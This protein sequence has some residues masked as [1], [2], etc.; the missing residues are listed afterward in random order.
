ME[1]NTW[2]FKLQSLSGNEYLK[3]LVFAVDVSGTNLLHSTTLSISDAEI[4][5]TLGMFDTY[6][7]EIITNN[8]S[9]LDVS[10]Y[11]LRWEIWSTSQGNETR[12][13][14]SSDIADSK[15]PNVTQFTQQSGN[16]LVNVLNLVLDWETN[17]Q[18][19]SSIS[20]FTW[21]LYIINPHRENVSNDESLNNSLSTITSP[22]YYL[23]NNALLKKCIGYIGGFRIIFTY[24]DNLQSYSVQMVIINS[25]DLVEQAINI[26][27][28]FNYHTIQDLQNNKPNTQVFEVTGLNDD[29]QRSQMVQNLGN[30]GANVV[31]NMPNVNSRIRENDKYIHTTFGDVYGS[32]PSRFEIT[33][34]QTKLKI[35]EPT[36]DFIYNPTEN[37]NNETT[38]WIL[39]DQIPPQSPG[40][41]SFFSR[42]DT[43]GYETDKY[44]SAIGTEADATDTTKYYR[45]GGTME[46]ILSGYNEIKIQTINP[47]DS[48]GNIGYWV[49]SKDVRDQF[50][51]ACVAR[52]NGTIQLYGSDLLWSRWNQYELL[53]SWD[54]VLYFY[55][56][57]DGDNGTTQSG[58]YIALHNHGRGISSDSPRRIIY[59]ENDGSSSGP[60]LHTG[61]GY[62]DSW[63]YLLTYGFQIWIRRKSLSVRSIIGNNGYAGWQWQWNNP[64]A[65]ALSYDSTNGLNIISPSID[66]TEATFDGSLASLSIW[67]I[68][69]RLDLFARTKYQMMFEHTFKL[70]YLTPNRSVVTYIRGIQSGIVNNQMITKK[71]SIKQ[72][73]ISEA[74]LYLLNIVNRIYN[75]QTSS[76]LILTIFF[77]V[78]MM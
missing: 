18:I 40:P 34:W 47:F 2:D 74:E 8:P 39:I 60:S 15:Y 70:T 54:N 59:I 7:Q 21:R 22:G 17:L 53:D 52:E 4:Y 76:L 71:F 27:D 41:T 3:E 62:H 28:F 67:S 23:N 35:V 9:N 61:N 68:S 38:E 14:Y 37:N 12:V 63:G 50:G 6:N 44:P 13:A 24:S 1:K 42:T 46:S 20:A 48:S 10:G 49:F 33:D 25:E 36:T 32:N 64:T 58:P 57:P 29:I 26:A 11:K 51:A 5:Y 78:Y 77:V 66:L 56:D 31:F 65:P 73:L 69:D 16:N 30:L 72:G 19:N 75:N 55:V 45:K 43:F